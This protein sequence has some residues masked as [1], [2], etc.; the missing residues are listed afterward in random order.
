MS[1]KD[2]TPSDA[3]LVA[4]LGAHPRHYSLQNAVGEVERL[5]AAHA[6]HRMANSSP[7]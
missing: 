4:V 7:P 3:G 5:G 1:G 6:R 2:A